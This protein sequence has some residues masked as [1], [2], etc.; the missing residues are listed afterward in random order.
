MKPLYGLDDASRKFYL[1]VKETL[2]ELGLKTLPGDDAFHYEHR[3][4]KLIGL[5][6]SDVD[7]FTIA[8][9]TDFVKRIVTGIKERFTVSKVEEDKFRFTGLDVKAKLEE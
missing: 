5:N 7:D 4:G 2:Q 3:D 9:D 1:K 8:G 6:L